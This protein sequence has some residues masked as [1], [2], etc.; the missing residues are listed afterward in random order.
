MKGALE[1]L[2]E[3]YEDV[4][5][6][7]KM[8][9][10]ILNLTEGQVNIMNDADP[11]KFKDYYD[12]LESV[13]KVYKDLN[14]TTQMDLLETLFGKMRGNQGAALIQAFQSG[15]IQKAYESAQNSSGSAMQEQERWLNS[16]QAKQQQLVASAQ[17]FSNTFLSS[18]TVKG[19]VDGLNLIIS[20]L[21]EVTKLLGTIPTLATIA[22]GVMGAKGYGKHTPICP[23]YA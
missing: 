15:Q 12:I 11:T 2:N 21:T 17:E 20:G 5:S 6:V 18:S 22:F 1:E 8:Q 7:S 16:I 13:A 23:V 3:E 9:T 10:K 19:S 14:Q 4:V